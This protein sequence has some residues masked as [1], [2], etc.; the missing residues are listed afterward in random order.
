MQA[1]EPNDVDPMEALEASLARADEAL[2]EAH[3]KIDQLRQE[4]DRRAI[5]PLPSGQLVLAY[6][7]IPQRV[8]LDQL[9]AMVHRRKATFELYRGEIPGRLTKG[10]RGRPALWDWATARPWLEQ[11][12]GILMPERFPGATY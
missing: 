1:P 8:T 3:R 5:L 4:A 12:F 6:P 10:S 2:A 7:G 11:K 9:A